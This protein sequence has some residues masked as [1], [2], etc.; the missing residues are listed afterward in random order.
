M[1]LCNVKRDVILTALDWVPMK[2]KTSILA[3]RLHTHRHQ[4]TNKAH[5]QS[6]L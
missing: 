6:Q 3:Y 1:L 2:K 5:A 4:K